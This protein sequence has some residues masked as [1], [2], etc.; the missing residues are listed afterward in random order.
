MAN[1]IP[2]E[3]VNEIRQSVNI[4]D[5][6]SQYVQLKK[7]GRNH[8]GFCPFHQE[9]TPSFSVAED[10]QIFHCFSCGRGGNVFKFLMEVDGLNFPESVMKVAEMSHFPLEGEWTQYAQ[11]EDTEQDTSYKKLIQLHE[12]TAD[13]FHHILLNTK[14]GEDALTYLEN[15]GLTKELIATFK[16]GFAPRERNVLHQFA[17]AKEFEQDILLESGLFVQRDSGELLDRFYDRI[18]FPIRNQQGKTVAFS[19][20]IFNQEQYPEAPKYL[21]SPETSIFNKRKVLFNLDLARASIR[22]EKEVILFE[23]F[24]DVIASWQAGVQNGVAS[25]G[26]SLTNEQIHMLSRLTNKVLISYDGDNAGIEATKRAIDILGT[27]PKFELSIVSLPDGL[28]PDDFI[29][30][31]GVD[32]YKELLAHGRDTLF[33]FKMRYFRKGKQLQNESERIAYIETILQELLT[34]SSAVERDVYLKQLA[35]EFDI[36]VDTLKEQYQSLL[37]NA[38]KQA[39][40]EQ[41][42][43]APPVG[44]NRQQ[45][46]PQ[47]GIVERGSR[48]LTDVDK[49]QRQL[50]KRLIEHQEALILLRS[51][52]PDFAFAHE[53][54]QLLF[55]LFEAF[56]A[57]HDMYSM[58][59][60]LDYVKD[61]H[62]QNL[63]AEIA[64]IELSEELEE[65]EIIDYADVIVNRYSIRTSI[66]EKRRALNE[67]TRIGDKETARSLM[68]E[69]VNLSRQLKEKTQ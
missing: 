52:F 40:T 57:E 21:N 23:G 35:I 50:L 44:E 37:A 67:A 25:M 6:V 8:F 56:V 18:M 10:K 55:V 19:G 1:L 27:N 2:E 4:I 32:A 39:R 60:F 63:L 62:L 43:Q 49:A 53:S 20:R 3:Q 51:H 38:K 69:V 66:Q 30:K 48:K 42:K 24:M 64:M 65:Q 17:V 26:T 5:V 11:N 12:E 31:L 68:I 34:L 9:R 16:I 47:Q 29:K 13:L 7:S 61:S 46:Q 15:R 33:S 58:S 22:R 59:S 28:D 36:S 54:Y 14:A 41:H 45:F